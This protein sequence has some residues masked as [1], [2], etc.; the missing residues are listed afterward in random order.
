MGG[1]GSDPDLQ[2]IITDPNPS[3]QNNILNV[4]YWIRITMLTESVEV[5]SVF[6]K[7]RKEYMMTYSVRFA[8]TGPLRSHGT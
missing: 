4:S 3:G 6:N 7:F 2:R 5:K 1:S 8:V